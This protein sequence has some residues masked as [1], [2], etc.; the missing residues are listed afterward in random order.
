[1]K[2][3]YYGTAAA[4]GWPGIFCRCDMCQAARQAGGKNI[5]TRS[6]ALLDDKLLF[7]LPPDTYMHM[8]HGGLDMPKIRHVLI[9]HTH[10]DHFY[11]EELLFRSPGFAHEVDGEIRLYGNDKMADRLQ[12]FVREGV[13]AVCQLRPF[14]PTEVAGYRVTALLA[15]HD[16][17]EQ[18]FIYLV[19]REGQALLYGND[20]GLFPDAT[21]EYLKGHKLAL[22]SLDC[23]MGAFQE[24]SNHMGVPDVI[25]A[26]ER[27]VAMG[28]ADENTRFIATH[29]SHNGRMLHDELIDAL[30]IH[31]IGVAFDGME[32]LV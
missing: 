23:T 14:E 11:P 18:C 25:Q 7:D 26:K 24:G 20:T 28:C 21:W 4:E 1:M 2:L 29:F 8:L 19:E 17:S 15:A 12:A 6:Q 5:R 27:L 3:M 32:A 9:T 16:R 13:V 10:Q 30:S 22:V 31:G